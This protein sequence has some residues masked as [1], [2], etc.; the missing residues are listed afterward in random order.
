V[1]RIAA[2]PNGRDELDTLPGLGI[3]RIR[4]LRKAGWASLDAL[5][6]VSLAEL[7]ALPGFSPRIATSLH[8]YL[9]AGSGPNGGDD[10]AES[11]GAP[12]SDTAP[13][14]A[15][16][17]EP[18]PAVETVSTPAAEGE[19]PA[20]L[21]QAET[22][23]VDAPASEPPAVESPAPETLAPPLSADEVVLREEA[24]L[25][26]DAEPLPVPE[27]LEAPPRDKVA[28]ALA[29]L[30]QR[31]DDL[32]AGP[33]AAAFQPALA[34]QLSRLRRLP[35]RYAG[36]LKKAPERRALRQI[37]RLSQIL[38]A[39]A[40]AKKLRPKRQEAW[41]DALR[42]RRRKLRALLRG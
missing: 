14:H 36:G 40:A 21:S 8:A 9:H 5:R 32:L 39:V 3:V 11:A 28:G 23:H 15:A 26:R 37:A 6:A 31:A 19:E 17:A 29:R 12:V 7:E 25:I 30:A 2:A 41:T 18:S 22:T 35:G 16:A 10:A 1:E 4:S 13:D 20:A 38:D 27:T 24:A 34:R 42:T 33:T